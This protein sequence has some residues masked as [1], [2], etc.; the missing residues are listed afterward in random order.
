LEDFTTGIKNVVNT[1][2]AKIIGYYSIMGQR[3]PQAPEK[4]IYIIQYDNGTAKKVMKY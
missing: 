3:L 2:D 4:G 1:N